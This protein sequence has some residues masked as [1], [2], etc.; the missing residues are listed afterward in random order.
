MKILHILRSKPDEMTRN[1]IQRSFEDARVIEI[2]LY[3]ENVN[4]DKLLEE[5]FNSNKVVCWW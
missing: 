2:P 5:I 1:I 3:E 4:Y